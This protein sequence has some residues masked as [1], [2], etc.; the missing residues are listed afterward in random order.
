MI[1]YTLLPIVSVANIIQR[2]G[3][4]GC[5]SFTVIS[6]SLVNSDDTAPIVIMAAT[7]GLAFIVGVWAAILINWLLWPFVARHELRKA[8]SNMLFF[9]SII[10][11][12]EWG[13]GLLRYCSDVSLILTRRRGQICIL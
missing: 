11:R 10:Y 4:V 2:S 7:R 9:L 1:T 13:P 12:G 8:V 6:L 3:V 5:L